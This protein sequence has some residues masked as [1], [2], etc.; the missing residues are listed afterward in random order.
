MSKVHPTTLAVVQNNLISTARE[1]AR[2]MIRCAFTPL[3]YEVLDFCC[4]IVD[5]DT[6]DVAQAPGLAT[7]LGT[8][9]P[10]VRKCL[11]I[12]GEDNLEP[13]DVI[14]A[15]N[16]VITGAHPPDA[17][18]FSPIFYEGTVFAYAANKAHSVD[19]GA[20]DVFPS[21]STDIFQEGLQIPPVKLYKNGKVQPEIREFIKWNSRTPDL[22]WGD[23]QA[24]VAAC[25][26]AEK[27]IAKLLDKYG[28][29]CISACI[30]E[31][32]D[33]G[34][35][36]TRAAIENIPDGTWTAEDYL[37]SNGVDKDKPVKMKVQVTVHGSDVTVDFTGSD[38][39]QKGPVNCPF[40]STRA[41]AIFVLKCVTTPGLPV[42]EGCHRPLK[43]VAAQN[44]IFNPGPLAPTTMYGWPVTQGVEVIAKALHPALPKRI[45]AASGADVIYVPIFGISRE[46]GKF[47]AHLAPGLIGHGASFSSDGENALMNDAEG[48]PRNIPIEVLEAREPILIEKYELEQDS[49]G[50]G[51]YRGGLGYRQ[52]KKLLEPASMISCIDRVKFPHWGLNG[53]KSGG[54]NYVIV[55]SKMKG[56]FEVLKTP[57]I[58]LDEGSKIVI[59]AGG[60]GGYGDPLKRS[61]EAVRLDVMN[62][63]VS[64]GKAKEDYGV[65]INP[66]D[67]AIDIEATKRL[68]GGQ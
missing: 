55:Q 3:I 9:A 11:D 57:A 5:A 7:F 38:E 25:R 21:D 53:G 42:N 46:T 28:R 8:L 51:E 56:E 40:I 19:L 16:P 59:G 58:E 67:F 50:A 64:L 54:R 47:W 22:V 23:I 30:Q 36:M 14:I 17:I 24:R 34:E 18:M 1:M 12:I 35:R 45:P 41:L 61:L 60:G 26:V 52:V 15:A 31:M 44:S 66:D 4:G 65:V 2:T 68:R 49:G 29:E 39:Q 32:Y 20:K 13:G 10:S 63:Y 6:R 27:R 62:G 48:A 43:I 33:Y 37:D